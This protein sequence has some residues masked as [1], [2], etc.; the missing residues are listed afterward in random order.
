MSLRAESKHSA[1]RIRRVLRY[2]YVNGWCSRESIANGCGLTQTAVNSLIREELSLR[3]IDGH[4]AGGG[5]VVK[6]YALPA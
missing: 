5:P 4:A 2:L 3:E 1:E 6:L